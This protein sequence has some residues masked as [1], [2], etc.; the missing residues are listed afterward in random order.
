LG[1]DNLSNIPGSAQENIS[2][3]PLRV[4]PAILLLILMFAARFVPAFLEGGLSAYWMFAVFGPLL[5]CVLMLI[6]WLAA[7]RA[8][9]RERVFGL[10]ALVGGVVITLAA[11]HP[12][13][14]GPGTTYLTLPMGMTCFALAVVVLRMKRPIIRT[15]TAVTLAFLGFFFSAFLRNEGMS[16]DYELT[17]HWRWSEDAETKLLAGRE[18]VPRTN[19]PAPAQMQ[20]ALSN[21]EWPGFRGEDRSGR[22]RGPKISTNWNSNPPRQLWKIAVGPAWSSFAVAGDLLFTQEQRGE[23]EGVVCYDAKTGGEIWRQEV[24]GRLDDPLGGPGPRAT[25]TIANGALYAVGSTGAFLRLDP[26]TGAIV[27]K[28]DLKAVAGRAVPM[29]GFSASPLIVGSTGIVYAGGDKGVLGFDVASGALRWSVPAGIDSY[30]SPQLSKVAGEN[31]VLM[32]SNDEL[33]F[34]QP[35]SGKVRLNYAWK[36][37]AYRAL[38]PRVVE[39][40]I[41]L[42]PSAMNVGTRAIQ[43][44]QNKDE[45]EAKELWTSRNLKPDFTDFVTYQGYVYGVDGGIFT[46]VDLKN[47]ERKWKG[48]RYGKGQVLLLENSGLLLISTEQ[49]DVT[50]LR[51]DPSAHEEVASFKAIS[52]KTWNHPVVVGDR[53]FIRNSQEAACFQLPL[54]ER[55]AAFRR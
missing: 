14:R 38:Q 6:W 15:G 43:I 54:L 21:P 26:L 13:M 35:E 11:A 20:G 51:A 27:W 50:L 34:L 37:M 17:T 16:G 2:W 40:D 47:G 23:K 53:L 22:S 3:R 31:L 1:V 25:P 46:C 30:S 32:L 44:S 42:L 49:G 7:S 18:T 33:L 9:W 29:W 8:T 12:T 52:G 39:G 4:W 36:F 19:R 41:V 55:T 48:G 24:E 45:L 28:Q 10:L 5:C